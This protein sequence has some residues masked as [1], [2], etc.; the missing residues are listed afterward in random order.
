MAGTILRQAADDQEWLGSTRKGQS[1]SS[2]GRHEETEAAAH[3]GRADVLKPA[4][5]YEQAALP[6]QARD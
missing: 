2:P 1:G 4:T 3:R 6:F 5:A